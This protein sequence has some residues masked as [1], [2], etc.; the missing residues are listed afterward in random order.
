MVMRLNAEG[1]ATLLT[2]DRESTVSL[3]AAQAADG[4]ESVPRIS[5]VAYN[6]GA[7]QL[8][9]Q[10]WP[11]IFDLA[12]TKAAQAVPYMS[13]HSMPDSVVVGH[14]EE[15]TITAKQ[16]KSKGLLSGVNDKVT[17]IKASAKNGFPWQVSLG[18]DSERLEFVESQATVKVN[19]KT[20]NGPVYVARDNLIRE[21]SILPIG[22][23]AGTSTTLAASYKGGPAMFEQWL[24]TN[25]FEPANLSDKQ[26]V[27]LQAQYD[28]EQ[29][30]KDTKAKEKAAK[31]AKDRQESEDPILVQRQRYAAER[32]RVDGINTLGTQYDNPV[33]TLDGKKVSLAAHAIEQGWDLNKAEVEMMKA[34]RPRVQSGGGSDGDRES[35]FQVL[36]AASAQAGKLDEKELT[37]RFT[38]GVLEAAHKK[39]KSRLGLQEMLYEAARL[40]GYT[41]SMNVKSNLRAVLEAAFSTVDLPIS[42]TTNFNTF[43][44]QGYNSVDDSWRKIARIGRVSDFK[45]ITN[46]R[47]TG[48]F[49]FLPV[50]PDGHIKHGAMA[51]GTFGNKANTYGIML[52]LTRVDIIN[53]N[54][55]ALTDTPRLMARGGKLGLVKAFWTEFMN[56]AAF[57]VAGNNNV[58]SGAL[59]VAGL[60]ALKT[61]FDKLK[62]SDGEYLLSAMKYLVVPTELE[63]TARQLYTSSN[64]AGAS[65]PNAPSDNPW[66]GR[67]EPISSPYLS[68]TTITGNSTTAYY[69]IADPNDVPVIEVVFLDGVETPTIETAEV[70][71]SQLGVQTRGFWDWGVRKQD[72][73]GGVRSTGV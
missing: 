24:T 37:K 29:R 56:N 43:L 31:E 73:K 60:S 10:Y 15:V 70:N 53:D 14:A 44:M 18:V 27:V 57:F 52:V 30:D 22:A 23:D 71:F 38:P 47:V 20:F 65:N 46:L 33:A 32:S 36:Q 26:K 7:L 8:R 6:G 39:Y 9:G 48:G 2:L 45:E 63:V 51:E 54:L 62:G 59:S 11:V 69:G 40:N 25:G 50:A 42:L 17:E 64:L 21:I 1:Q 4:G 16:V 68:D 49:T 12:T 66:V 28:N 41:G 67:F 13:A 55:G 3:E 19:G 58:S 34:A 5:M 72:P 61:V 35:T